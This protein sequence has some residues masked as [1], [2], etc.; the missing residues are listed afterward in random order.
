[1]CKVWFLIRIGGAQVWP[2]MHTA[3]VDA[4]VESVTPEEVRTVPLEFNLELGYTRLFYDP[5][6]LSVNAIVVCRV[7]EA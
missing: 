2:V 4:G 7:P 5:T 1:M 6:C 3:L